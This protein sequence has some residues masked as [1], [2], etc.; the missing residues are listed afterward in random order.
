VAQL[1]RVEAVELLD[2]GGELAEAEAEEGDSTEDDDR[3]YD[4]DG[5]V[6]AFPHGG[7]GRCGDVL[8]VDLVCKKKTIFD[9]A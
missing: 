6:G 5:D 1:L 3:D 7:A 4:D 8:A 9:S 2:L